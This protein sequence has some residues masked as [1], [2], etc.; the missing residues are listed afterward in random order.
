MF[1]GKRFLPFTGTPIWK[2]V[3]S[4][5]L[6]ADCEPEP[7]TVATCMLKSLMTALRVPPRPSLRATSEIAIL[8]PWKMLPTTRMLK[9]SY[10]TQ[11]PWKAYTRAQQQTPPK[12]GVA[13]LGM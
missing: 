11:N 8:T 7:L 10:G 4:R 12:G 6:F 5:M 9:H 3:R 13:E 2:I 1:D